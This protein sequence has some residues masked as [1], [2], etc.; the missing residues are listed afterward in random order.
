MKINFK[1]RT[2]S[3]RSKEDIRQFIFGTLFHYYCQFLSTLCRDR[4]MLILNDQSI[5]KQDT[6]MLLF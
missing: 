3:N 6:K 4:E 2:E 5:N 1:S